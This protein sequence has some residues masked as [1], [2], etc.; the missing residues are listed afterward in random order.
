MRKYYSVLTEAGVN[1]FSAAA[2]TGVPVGFAAMAVGDGNGQQ[3]QPDGSMTGL[4]NERYRGPLNNLVIVDPE[5][6]I[7]RAE[8]VIP[9][10]TG[11]FWIREA[12]LYND[13]GVCLA[14]ANVADAYKPL[15]AEGSGRN[16][17][18]R[19]WIAVSDTASVELKS[20][21]AAILASQEDLLRVKNDTK[22]YSDEQVSALEKV[23]I[24]NKKAADDAEASLS[25]SINRL[26]VYTD[27]QNETLDTKLRDVI[28]ETVSS[29]IREAWEDD[30]P[31]GTV[32]FF[33]ANVNPN[34]RWPWSRW[35]YTGENKSIRIA[36]A[37][38]SDVG[39]T[40]G[41]D[42]VTL[43]QGNLP[44]VQINVTGETSEQ[45]QQELTTS[46]NGRHRHRAGDGA[47]GDTWQEASHGTDNQKYTGWNYTDYSEDHQHDVTIPAH[48]HTTSGKTA[49][50][51]E[52]KSFSVVE[53]HTLLMC[54]SRVA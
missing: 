29:A 34:T 15:L 10:Q 54:W 38:G 18:I 37:D 51:G 19:V 24:R 17:S 28:A 13:E 6:N 42:N 30:N 39:T 47:P 44:A 8:M 53:A 35:V 48:K 20:D 1:A 9:P 4:V 12:A 40:G 32:R 49:N 45:G 46:G 14:V 23:V 50:L 22:D 11:G 7:I 27:E 25:D 2:V 36:S 26:K 21:N 16:Q 5:K 33:S 52:G 3:I 43:Q 41:S 31:K